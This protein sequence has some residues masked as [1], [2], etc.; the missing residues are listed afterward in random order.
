MKQIDLGGMSFADLR[1]YDMYYVDKTGLIKDILES[2]SFG[3]FLFTR[4]RRFGKTTNLSMLDA[5]FNIE[6][7]GNTW[8]DGL[9]ISNHPKF[10]VHRNRYPVIRLNLGHAKSEDYDGFISGI[11]RAINICFE[12]H[13]RLLNG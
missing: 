11:R 13:R 3:V 9:E 12:S 2:N 5:F 8:F 10:D 7:K 6:Y 4:P 1:R